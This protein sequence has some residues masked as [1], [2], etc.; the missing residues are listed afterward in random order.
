[1]IASKALAFI[2]GLM[3]TNMKETGKLE[4]C[5]GKE[6]TDKQTEPSAKESGSRVNA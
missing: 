2:P 3:D 4:K 5:T 6:Y 1:M